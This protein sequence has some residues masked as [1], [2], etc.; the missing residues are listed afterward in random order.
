MLHQFLARKALLILISDILVLMAAFLVS[1]MLRVGPIQRYFARE[2]QSLQ[3]YLVPGAVVIVLC[4][5]FIASSRLYEDRRYLSQLEQYANLVKAMTYGILCSFGLSFFLKAHDYSRGVL[6]LFWGFGAVGLI[7]ERAMWNRM[8]RKLRRLGWDVLQ[9]AVVE[10]R[11]HDHRVG[12]IVRKFPELGYRPVVYLNVGSGSVDKTFQS[13]EKLFSGGKIDGVL[14]GATP[15]DYHRVVPYLAWCEERDLMH[16]QISST[17][18]AF[19]GDEEPEEILRVE[20][21]PFFAFVKRVF[22]EAATSLVLFI[23]APL[24]LLIIMAIKLDSPGPA[25]FVQERVGR[26][27][28]LFQMYKFRTM[29]AHTPR[30]AL[31]VRHARDS[32]VTWV[33]EFLRRTS[34]DELPQLLNVLKGEMSLVG[35]RPEMPFMI[36]KNS[37]TYQKRLMVLPGVTGLWQAIARHEPLEESLRYDLYYIRHRSFLF[38]LIILARTVVTVV[39]GRGAS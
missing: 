20:P 39:S 9:V 16:H 4:V 13:L 28:R 3:E 15:R 26:N 30:Y 38:D 10:L 27:G 12:A 36:K 22:D 5:L 34:L 37:L 17:F 7:L 23:T 31:T 24:W 29:Y 1:Y 35:P 14:V 25:L 21:K 2:I 6:A 32:R 18:E 19:H 11:G 8:L 33:G